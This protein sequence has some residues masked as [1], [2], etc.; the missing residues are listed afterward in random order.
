MQGL[1]VAL[2]KVTIIFRIGPGSGGTTRAG[3][4]EVKAASM[5]GPA[6][7]SELQVLKN[8]ARNCVKI[9][10]RAIKLSRFMTKLVAM[11]LP[12]GM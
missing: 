9:R 8:L 5:Y 3:R 12:K 11:I 2:L 4:C 10:Y 1:M 7:H 6:R